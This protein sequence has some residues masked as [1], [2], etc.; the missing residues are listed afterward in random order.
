MGAVLPSQPIVQRLTDFIWIGTSPVL[1]DARCLRVAAVLRA[2]KESL[3]ALDN[4][5]DALQYHP[6]TT[7]RPSEHPRFFPFPSSY[8]VASETIKFRYLKPLDS[9]DPACVTYLAQNIQDEQLIV[10]KFAQTYGEQAHRLLAQQQMAP[11]LYYCG[12]V[13]EDAGYDNLKLVVME[14]VKG[15]T[16][17]DRYHDQPLP[18]NVIEQLSAALDILH[19]HNLVFGDL[20]KPNI[21]IRSDNVTQLVDFDWSGVHDQARYPVHLSRDVKW[22]EGVDSYRTLSKQ[23]DRDMLTLLQY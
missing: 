11:Q 14:Y 8:N 3:N 13:G 16:A 5:Y 18:T 4:Y 10:V 6:L 2:L 7:P 20:R 1:T 19:S 9:S 12:R 22:P 17:A 23:H 21:M 15:E